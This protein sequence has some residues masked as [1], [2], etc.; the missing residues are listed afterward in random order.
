MSTIATKPNKAA[1]LAQVQALIAGTE[2]HFPNG[3]FTLGNTAYT[4]ATL[5]LA[6]QSLEQGLAALSA[7][8]AN[9]KDAVTKFRSVETTAARFLR[10]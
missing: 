7:A 8:Q 9:A 4:T 10:D 1:T 2:K 6:L 5:V 3:S